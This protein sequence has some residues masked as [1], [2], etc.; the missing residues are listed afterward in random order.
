MKSIE[1]NLSVYAQIDGVYTPVGTLFVKGT[2][3]R[4]FFAQFQYTDSYLQQAKTNKSFALD[5]INLPLSGQIFSTDSRYHILGVLF[6]AAPD[7]WGRTVMAL[8]E[9]IS[10][11]YLDENTIL[12]KGRGAGVGSIVFSPYPFSDNPRF[13][14]NLPH[15]DLIPELYQTITDIDNGV[16]IKNNIH[17][18][19]VSSWDIG[20]A[21]PKAVVEDDN[22]TQWIVKFPR[23][24]DSFNKE[25]V[26]WASLQ[27][28]KAIGINV[29]ES[30][31]HELD[32]GN[33]VLL[34]KRFDRI[35]QDRLHYISAA[36]LISPPPDF[37]KRQMDSAYGASI[38]S[39][40]KIADIIRRIS[41][42]AVHDIQELYARMVLNV[43]INNTD[44]HLK[45]IGFLLAP[46]CLDKYELSPVFDILTQETENRHMLHIGPDQGRLGTVNNALSAAPLFGLK[47]KAAKD[48]VVIIQSVVDMRN[49]YYKSAGMSDADMHKVNRWLKP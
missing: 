20:G 47:S 21:R 26:E 32:D 33:C 28:A 39:Y 30:H 49:N 23:V 44:D 25:R 34:I 22:G 2:N 45:N 31:L 13:I 24:R 36:S 43:F 11:D 35:K 7:A 16:N 48:I 8:D 10:P 14:N 42:R 1:P 40:A 38:F 9:N 17:N 15:I 19:L 5:P 41:N 4:D 3:A 29:P 27:M 37:D 18:A 12:L 6:D 46:G